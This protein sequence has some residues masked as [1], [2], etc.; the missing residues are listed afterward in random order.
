MAFQGGSKVWLP[1]LEGG[2]WK[3]KKRGGS[4]VQGQV[5]LKGG[6]GAGTLHI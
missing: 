6:W 2:I 5:F 3:I 4:M 1:P